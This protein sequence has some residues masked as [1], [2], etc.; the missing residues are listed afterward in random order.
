GAPMSRRT[1]W[2]ITRRHV[3]RAPDRRVFTFVDGAGGER[4]LS[5][6]EL[7]LRCRTLGAFLQAQG[8]SGEP[9][10][11]LYEP[12]LEFLVAF[13][14]CHYAGASAV[15]AYPPEPARLLRT[16]PRLAAIAKDTRAR[17]VLTTSVVR[18][19]APALAEVGLSGLTWVATDEPLAALPEMWRAPDRAPD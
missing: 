18:A 2:Q 9:V 1:L 16:L 15:P 13:H 12:G 10:L 7:D 5:Y 17:V 6:G 11:L 4:A 3:E 8:L 19:A 14:G